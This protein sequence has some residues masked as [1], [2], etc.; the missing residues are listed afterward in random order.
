MS[1]PG[2]SRAST[3]EKEFMAALLIPYARLCHPFS[4]S[5]PLFR[6]FWQSF[7]ILRFQSSDDLTWYQVTYLVI[8]DQIFQVLQTSSCSEALL[9]L[10]AVRVQIT[11]DGG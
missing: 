8:G 3:A 11:G 1:N 7:S 5:V 4:F 10:L 9:Y 6:H 2:F